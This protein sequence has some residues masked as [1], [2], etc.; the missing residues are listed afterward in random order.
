MESRRRFKIRYIAVPLIILIA[1]F[2]GF[3][4]IVVFPDGFGMPM[5]YRI[6]FFGKS[7]FELYSL[8]TSEEKKIGMEI[9]ERAKSCME[10]TGDEISAP[11]NDA[12][13]K[14]YYFRHYDK[15]VSTDVQ[16]ELNKAVI[17]SNEGSVWFTYTLEW[18]DENNNIIQGAGNILTRCAIEK[19]ENGEW[20]VTNVSEPA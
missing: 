2:I 16:V 3:M 20:V 1:V 7:Y 5:D 15:P 13:Y 11:V 6:A 19:N 9:A 10:Y 12:L 8:Q 17:H 4:G 18:Y 14:Y